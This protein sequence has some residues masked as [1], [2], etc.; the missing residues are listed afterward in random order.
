ML[1]DVGAKKSLGFT[2][3]LWGE[4]CYAWARGQRNR[5][6]GISLPLPKRK[7]LAVTRS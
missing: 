1:V 2:L 7:G 3:A 6:R 4:R 5:L